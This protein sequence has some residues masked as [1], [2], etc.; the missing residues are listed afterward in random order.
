MKDEGSDTLKESSTA[1]S[2]TGRPVVARPMRIGVVGINREW[3]NPSSFDFMT[4][5]EGVGKNTG[6]LMFTEAMFALIDGDL[7]S[8]GFSF[9]PQWVNANLDAVVVPAAN[10]LNDYADWDWL[11]VRLEALTVPVTVIGLGLQSTIYELSAVTVNASCRRLIEFF[12]SQPSP[13][14]VRGNFT[15]DWLKSTGVERVVTTGCPS[16]YMNIFPQLGAPNDGKLVFQGTR[17]GMSGA[18]LQSDSINRRM[19]DFTAELDCPMIYQSEFEE[20]ALLT[21]GQSSATLGEHK[22]SLL[23]QLYGC[24]TVDAL[25]AFLKRN[26]RVFYELRTWSAFVSEYSAV[27]GT[28]LHGSILALNSGR[29]SAL[30]PHDSRTAEVASFAGVQAL[31]GPVV[32]DCQSLDDFKSLI[33][34]DGL[35]RYRDV[36][37]QNQMTFVNF[38]RDAGLRPRMEMMF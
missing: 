13:I 30:V 34:E 18:F 31:L 33:S 20:M 4:L 27:V 17:Y 16:I 32:R 22:C 36:R 15:R 25:D 10:W 11:V 26:G 1:T 28:R 5:Y 7:T 29:M 21:S 2:A 35:R 14:S 24:T 6:N 19:F 12:A 38:L 9:D 8:I 23:M 37:S 3:P